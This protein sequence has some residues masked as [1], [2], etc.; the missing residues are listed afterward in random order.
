[1][2]I[3]EQIMPEKVSSAMVESVFEQLRANG[4][5]HGQIISLS[6]E[7]GKLAGEHLAPREEIPALGTMTFEMDLSGMAWV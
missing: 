2:R 5:S 6:K 1:M 3:I 4:Y 7:L